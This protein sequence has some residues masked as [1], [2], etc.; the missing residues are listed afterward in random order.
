MGVRL[1]QACLAAVLLAGAVTASQ[2]QD[3]DPL[4]PGEAFVTRFS[5]TTET[6]GTTVIDL[7]GTVGSIVDLRNPAQPPRGQHWL[8]EPQRHAVTAKEVGQVF[9]VALDDAPAPNIYLTATSAFGLH[10]TADGSAWM[11]G[12]WGAGGGPGTVWKIDAASGY[13]PVVFA[14]IG[15][16]GRA[17]TGAALG[18]I[19]YDKWHRQLYVSDL[20][21][22]L[23]HRLRLDDGADLG[24]FDHGVDGRAGF[25]DAASGERR[26]L[27]QVAFDPASSARMTDCPEGAFERTP[28]CWNLAD[29]RRRVWGLGVRKDARSGQVR[30]YYAVWSSQA[31]GSAGFASAA[32]EER[33]NAVWS[34]A[35]TEAGDFDKTS[36]RREFFL[37]DF[38]THPLDVKRFGRSHP[39]SD[40]AFCKCKD[41][42]IMLVSERGGLR[43]LGLDKAEAFARPHESR[44]LRYRLDEKGRWKLEGR[45]DVG[46]YDRKNDRQPFLRAGSSGGV[47]FGYGYGTEWSMDRARPDETVWMTGDSLCAPHGPCFNPDTGVRNDGSQVHGAQGTP[48]TALDALLP[49]GATKPYP[50]AGV[51]YPPT[52]PLQSYMI[53]AD[54]NVDARGDIILRSLTRNDATRIGDIEI[55]APCEAVTEEAGGPE[56]VE[57]PGV[58]EPPIVEEPEAPDTPDLEKAKDGPAQCTEGGICTFTVTITNNG[59]GTW[60][61]PLWEI[62]TL[63]PGAILWNYAPQPDWTCAQSPGTD[64]V[65][66]TYGWAM[67]DPGDQVTLTMDVLLP[68]GLTGPAE[69][70]I[71]NV[72]LPSLD[73]NDPAV[74]LLLEQALNAWGY[75]VGPIDG[76]LDAVTMNGIRIIQADN[77]L[78]VTGIPDQTLI[79]NLF[80]GSAALLAD[81]NPANDADCHTVDIQPAPA[82]APA[83]APDIQIR[84]RQRTARCRPGGVCAFDLWFINRGPVDW[85]GRPAITDTLPA[86]ATVL[87]STGLWVCNQ[88]GRRLDCRYPMQVRLAPGAV[89]RVTITVRM[90]RG[91][92]IGAQNCAAVAAGVDVTGDPDLANNRQCIPIRVAPPP[93]PDLQTL[94][95]QIVGLCVLGQPCSFDLWFINR[96]PGRWTGAPV[97]LD[98]LPPGAK[99]KGA[100]APWTC[101]QTGRTVTCRHAK[102]TLPP[103]KGVN[104]RINAVLPRAMDKGAR[105]CV[106][107]PRGRETR[108]DPVAQ[109]NR[110]CVTIRTD[111]PEPHSAPPSVPSPA[112]PSP[113]PAAPPPSGPATDIRIEKTQLGPCKP[114]HSCLFEIKFINLGPGRWTGRPSVSDV[115]PPGGATLGDWMPSSWKCV[116][117]P[118][119]ISCEHSKVT[120]APDGRLS[121]TIAI[122][123][124]DYLYSSA[125]NC[126]LLSRAGSGPV[127]RNAMNDMD[128]VS[129]L[130]PTEGAAPHPPGAVTPPPQCPPGTRLRDGQ[131]IKPAPVTRSCPEGYKRRGDRCYKCPRGYVLKG[132]RCYSRRRTCPRGYVLR[133]K[134]CYAKRRRCPRGYVRRGNRCYRIIRRRCP[135]GYLRV[136][137][138]CIQ[139]KKRRPPRPRPGHGHC[140]GGDC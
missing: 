62:D 113:P 126:A 79:D 81:A 63:P 71:A 103:G 48:V 10:R 140:P 11:P 128:C 25:L 50:A 72:R 98:R 61:G 23:I 13:R 116:Q 91:L 132:T 14:H 53:D 131:C 58:E 88:A 46:F 41:A 15:V 69:N 130:T 5:G 107:I 94:K 90:P 137:N 97:L 22:G 37:P 39:V 34:V 31:L 93:A 129:I 76:V 134:R 17:N 104:V 75:P 105:N 55:Y 60:S 122:R 117:G 6:G 106:R 102:I 125:R 54:I 80:G 96:G 110:H 114:G 59:P 24:Q 136:G 74:I 115:P 38:F 42:R 43:N 47:D 83:A 89:R 73:P 7:D 33:R 32:S 1:A 8:N 118:D 77:G 45:Y 20:E 28:S 12:M 16:N 100:T 123:M 99:L 101:K 85:T 111:T 108:R 27:A 82:P 2:A 4:Q 44:V 121:L 138:L 84:K 30:L 133:G 64:T 86:G 78:P 51:P 29:F 9:G 65:T 87:R 56:L 40:I 135:P 18:N 3:S 139:I 70:C 124:P 67:L 52:G 68:M 57:P 66:C 109:N 35:I 127:D 120:L 119:A 36:V 21:T 92:T 26:S 112:P 49:E 95:Q 19:A